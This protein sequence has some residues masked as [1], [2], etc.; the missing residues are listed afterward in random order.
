MLWRLGFSGSWVR[1][2]DILLRCL[3]TFMSTNINGWGPEMGVAMLQHPPGGSALCS[4]RRLARPQTRERLCA[5]TE[6]EPVSPPACRTGLR[7][8]LCRPHVL[9]R[10]PL[11]LTFPWARRELGFPHLLSTLWRGVLHLRKQPWLHPAAQAWSL[12]GTSVHPVLLYDTT[13]QRA[14]EVPLPKP[15]SSH[16]WPP[17]SL[18]QTPGVPAVDAAPHESLRNPVTTPL[19]CVHLPQFPGY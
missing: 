11:Y 6:A 16:P 2:G 17:P 9:S 15:S 7:G 4:G 5:P 10:R 12:R 3:Y 13:Y 18:L 14:P 19:L 8:T 1:R